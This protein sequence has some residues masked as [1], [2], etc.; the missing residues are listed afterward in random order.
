ML[1]AMYSAL[2]MATPRASE[3]G[4]LRLGLRTSPAVKVT[5]FQESEENRAPTM[6]TPT[7][8]TESKFQLA[9][10]QKSVK[11]LATAAGLRP[12]RRPA[13]TRPSSVPTLAKVNTFCT[14]APVRMPFVLLHVRKTIT[15]ID[16]ACC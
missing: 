10:P 9:E 12:T 6:A 4:R 13:P 3:R 11:L 7:R 16:R 15:A 14:M 5:L 2:T 8:R 1:E